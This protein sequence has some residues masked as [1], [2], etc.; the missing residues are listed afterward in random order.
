MY[1]QMHKRNHLS[2]T[3]TEKA[4][5]AHGKGHAEQMLTAFPLEK[6]GKMTSS[7]P[8]VAALKIRSR[9][10]DAYPNLKACPFI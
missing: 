7:L 1:I 8:F 2:D 10:D 9:G 3:F 6:A 5:F 4:E